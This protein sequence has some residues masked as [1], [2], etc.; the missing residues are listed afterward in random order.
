[1]LPPFRPPLGFNAANPSSEDRRKRS[2]N[3][4]GVARHVRQQ[5][6]TANTP[7]ALHRY[8]CDE[9]FSRLSLP[10]CIHAAGRSE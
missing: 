8:A 5:C 3:A 7:N 2:L 9:N 1:L 10:G 6:P 4:S